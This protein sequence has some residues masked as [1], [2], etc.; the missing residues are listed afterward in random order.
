M[1]REP[2]GNMGTHHATGAWVLLPG[3][4]LAGA[5]VQR[6]SC[7]V[8]GAGPPLLLL[9][10]RGAPLL[11][12]PHASPQLLL[13]RLRLGR[14]LHLRLLLRRWVLLLLL[15]LL[16]EHRIDVHSRLAQLDRHLHS[17]PE[18]WS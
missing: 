4:E 17:E 10:L 12:R 7:G 6:C 2:C 13:L 9:R 18:V 16:P 5:W 15:P 8:A 1:H 3:A 14:R 11:C